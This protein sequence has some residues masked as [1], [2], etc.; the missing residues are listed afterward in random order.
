MT[1]PSTTTANLTIG[2]DLGD[3]TSHVCVLD[4]G[5]EVIESGTVATKPTATRRRRSPQW[6]QRRMSTANV[7]SRRSA[8]VRRFEA[9]AQ[10]VVVSACGAGG[11]MRSRS[12]EDGRDAPSWFWDYGWR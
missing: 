7:R 1:E 4:T 3:G 10:S 5:G 9:W 12:V 11:T 6:G 2:I 8:Q